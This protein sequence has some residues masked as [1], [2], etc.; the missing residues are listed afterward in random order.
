MT[1]DEWK[2]ID[3]ADRLAAELH[4]DQRDKGDEPYI[5]HPRRVKMKLLAG[6][7]PAPMICAGVL[8]DVVEDT[9]MTLEE[10]GQQFPARVVELVDRL[11]RRPGETYLAFIQRIADDKEAAIIKLADIDDNLDATRPYPITP[12]LRDRYNRARTILRK[13]IE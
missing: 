6:E 3:R 9:S 7:Y 1:Q 13:V 12:S 4:K 5:R 11:S 10:L 8:H 2:M